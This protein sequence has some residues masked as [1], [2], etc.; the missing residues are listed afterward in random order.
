MRKTLAVLVAAT[1]TGAVYAAVALGA[2]NPLVATGKASSITNTFGG[3]SATVNPGGRHTRYFFQYGLT[4][5]YGA[6]TAPKSAGSGTKALTVKATLTGLTPGTSYHYRVVAFNSIGTSY[7]QDR[8]FKTSGHPPPGAVTGGPLKVGH[9]FAVLS[10]TVVTNGQATTWAFK[11]GPAAGVY[12]ATSN[13]GI[14]PATSVASTVSETISPL[15][16]GTTFHY[17]LIALHPNAAPQVGQDLTFTTLPFPRPLPRVRASTGPHRARHKPYLF[18]TTGQVALPASIPAALGCNGTVA[19]RYF[20]GH[21]SVALGLAAVQPN[22]SFGGAVTFHKLV[23]KVSTRLRVEIRFRG[24]AYLAST[25]AR[26]QR[27]RLG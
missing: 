13:G 24:N 17:V 21:R 23:N 26:V 14:V 25:S 1:V 4:A 7:G 12:T 10:G 2:S 15:P 11:Y 5:G 8:S 9:G 16:T 18:S 6:L 22:C 19:I 20:V 3:V 27:V